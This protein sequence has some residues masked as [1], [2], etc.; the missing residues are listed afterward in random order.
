MVVFSTMS[1]RGPLAGFLGFAV[2]PMII[3]KRWR[4]ATGWISVIIIIATI[5]L[6]FVRTTVITIGL[7]TILFPVLNRGKNTIQIILI[8][9]V[10]A[11]AGIYILN[12]TPSSGKVGERLQTIGSITEDGSFK[13]RI[14]IA[15]YGAG[16]LLKNPL[17]TGLGSTGLAGRVNT[18]VLEAGAAI[19]DNG[20]FEILFAFGLLGGGFFFYALYLI[21]KQVRIF[22]KLGIRSET[23]MM[24]KAL[25]VTGAVTLFAGN[26]LSGPGS[27]VFCVFAGFAAYPKPAMDR[28]VQAMAD[29]RRRKQA[30]PE[31]SIL[32]QNS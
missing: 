2:I 27:V 30:P 5:L 26:W 25:F 6:T 15:N 9:C 16:A 19:G 22:E 13:G 1:E 21:W 29:K 3:S 28:I 20:Y 4:N 24:F 7:A 14:Q 18:G 23:L 12:K 31:G 17:G 32:Q 10:G 11:V 8:L